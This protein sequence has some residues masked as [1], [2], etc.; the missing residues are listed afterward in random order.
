[1]VENENRVPQKQWRKWSEKARQVFNEVYGAIYW[2]PRIIRHPKQEPMPD[3]HWKTLSWN[4][5]WLAA[6]AVDESIPDVCGDKKT[7]ATTKLRKVA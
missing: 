1:M 2:N 5:A 6:D 7:G 3:A 4:A